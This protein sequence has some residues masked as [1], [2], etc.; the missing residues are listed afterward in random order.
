[1]VDFFDSEAEAMCAPRIVEKLPS[2]AFLQNEKLTLTELRQKKTQPVA[3]LRQ[4]TV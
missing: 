3:G 2:P 1:L 4:I